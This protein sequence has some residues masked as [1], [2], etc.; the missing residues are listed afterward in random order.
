M[1]QA[2]P[3]HSAAPARA[4]QL[5]AAS[6]DPADFTGSAF[7]VG[8][9]ASYA[10][11]A[12]T[13]TG[14]SRKPPSGA[15]APAGAGSAAGA[16]RSR[17]RPVSLDQAAWNCPWPAPA[18]AQDVDEQTVVLRAR[19]R[20]DGHPEGVDVLT[21]PG[22]GFGAAARLCALTTRFEP[23]LDANG[24]SIAAQSPLIRVHFFR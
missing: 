16:V 7:I 18:D 9:G 8:T 10:G 23:A 2:A 17:A 13:S 4:G 22:F 14:V 12:T 6:P 5:A 21:D 20:A 3:T 24:Q 15:V 11:G 1:T 19:V